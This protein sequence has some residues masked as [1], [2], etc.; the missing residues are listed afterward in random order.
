MM[1]A[2]HDQLNR[3]TG[4]TVAAVCEDP[5]RNQEEALFAEACPSLYP[6][7]KMDIQPAVREEK[8]T[9]PDQEETL[10]GSQNY[11]QYLE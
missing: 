4:Q 9:V 5:F 11:I 10:F 3:L 2:Y 6:G 8:T 1:E 7:G